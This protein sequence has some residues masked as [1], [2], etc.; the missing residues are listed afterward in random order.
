MVFATAGVRQDAAAAAWREHRFGLSPSRWGSLAGKGYWVVGAGTGFGQAIAAAL[1]LAGGTVVLS[2][3][4]VEKLAETRAMAESLGARPE[5]C[6][7]LACDVI[8]E[9]QIVAAVDRMKS[10]GGLRGVVVSAALPSPPGLSWP[11]QTLT[12]EGWDMLIRSN[13]TAPWLV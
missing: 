2:G 4:R 10:I 11:L 6:M 5:R 12:A 1:A 8:D 3:R 7:L 13:V 9:T